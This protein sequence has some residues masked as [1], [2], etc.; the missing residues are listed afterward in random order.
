MVD[1]DHES[2]VD[3]FLTAC[4]GFDAGILTLPAS[5]PKYSYAQVCDGEVVRTAE[6][7][8]ISAYGTVGLY[9]FRHGSDFVK[10]AERMIEDGDRFKNEFYVCPV[11]NY[12]PR[13]KRIGFYN[14]PAERA[15]FLG[16]PEEYTKYVNRA[17]ASDGGGNASDGTLTPAKSA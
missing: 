15:H 14:I 1:W 5:E 10:A 4:G 7:Q 2:G 6:K 12:L 9:W 17:R 11:F 8:V 13:T 16:A 3:R